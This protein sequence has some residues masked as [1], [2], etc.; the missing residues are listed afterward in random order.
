[1]VIHTFDATVRNIVCAISIMHITLTTWPGTSGNRISDDLATFSDVIDNFYENDEGIGEFED[2]VNIV[3]FRKIYRKL[4]SGFE[5]WLARLGDR[6]PRKV[7]LTYDDI[8][9][10]QTMTNDIN[11]GDFPDRLKAAFSSLL[12]IVTS[13]K[14]K[15]KAMREGRNLSYGKIAGILDPSED[16]EGLIGNNR[17]AMKRALGME[18]FA[19]TVGSFLTNEPRIIRGS[20][21]TVDPALRNLRLRAMGQVPEPLKSHRA[22]RGGNRKKTMRTNKYNKKS[23]KTKK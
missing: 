14:R 4:N 17:P 19:T 11:R 3:E 2:A 8:D 6:G 7:I 22:R 16:R 18:G 21:G 20:K 10:I 9:K 15:Q 5:D 23:R 12:R 1:M 13:E